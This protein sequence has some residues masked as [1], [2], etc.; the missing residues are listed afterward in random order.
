MTSSF[1][2]M[3]IAGHCLANLSALA[4]YRRV[5]DALISMGRRMLQAS[6]VV[7]ESVSRLQCRKACFVGS[8]ALAAV[9][10]ECGLKT[11]ELT[12][13]GICAMA[14]STMGL[15]HGPMSAMDD[16]TLF[17]SLISGEPPRA[18]YELDLLEEIRAKGLGRVRIAVAPAATENLRRLT[19]HVIALD[20]PPGFPD[21]YRA[22]VDVIVGQLLGL[23]SSL[24]AG[25]QP[26]EPSPN[27]T[28]TRV[29]SRVKIY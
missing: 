25:L 10:T 14:E 28:I 17:V 21:D 12:A 27:G 24:R 26:D 23:F 3:V 16:D 19:D 9:A 20:A 18:S 4:E 8:G 6:A 13:G 29:V 2:N 7:A 22:P 11:Q 5:L 1:T 15:R